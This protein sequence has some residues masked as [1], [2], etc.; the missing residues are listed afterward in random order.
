MHKVY[1]LARIQKTCHIYIVIHVA[2]DFNEFANYLISLWYSH[3][4]SG[5]LFTMI[6][7]ET[8]II[9]FSFSGSIQP[10]TLPARSWI[11]WR[12]SHTPFVLL[13]TMTVTRS[14]T[15]SSKHLVYGAPTCGSTAGLNLQH[16]V[17]SKRKLTWF[18]DNGFVDG[19]W[20]DSLTIYKSLFT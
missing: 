13:S 17:L 10:M 8:N 19:W 6:L 20:V 4:K 3:Y 14:T 5:H 11:A 1:S 7:I 9:V 2:R 16:T 18:V 12:G 15:S